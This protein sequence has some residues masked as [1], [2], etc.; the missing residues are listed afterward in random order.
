MKISKI[1]C[2]SAISCLLLVNF[3]VPVQSVYATQSEVSISTESRIESDDLEE[4]LEEAKSSPYLD[5]QIDGD[6]F[7]ITF[8]DADFN[9]ASRE[10]QGLPPG[11]VARANGVNKIQGKLTSG[12]FK[13]Y[14]TANTLNAVKN[15]GGSALSFLLGGGWGFVASSIYNVVKADKNFK[16]GRVFVYKGFQYQYWYYQ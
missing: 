4:M 11:R 15:I 13:V 6:D 3:A 14:L 16:H 1:S 2:I 10:A 7:T 9:Q 5:V 8:T 12:N